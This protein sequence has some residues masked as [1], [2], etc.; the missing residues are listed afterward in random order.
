MLSL[1]TAPVLMSRKDADMVAHTRNFFR[2]GTGYQFIQG[3]HCVDV[4]VRACVRV[5][6]C[7]LSLWS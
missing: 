4:R 6:V 7:V 5:C 2:E 1:L 3:V